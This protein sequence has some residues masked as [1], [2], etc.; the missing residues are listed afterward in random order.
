MTRDLIRPWPGPKPYQEQDA[1]LFF[2]REDDIRRI[3]SSI[4]RQ[5]LTVLLA[6]SGV[7]KTSLLQAGVLPRLRRL[8]EEEPGNVGPIVLVRQWGRP[9]PP[10]LALVEAIREELVNLGGRQAEAGKRFCE[11]IQELMAVPCPTT[12]GL[13]DA[14]DLLDAAVGY[15]YRLTQSVGRL[16]L[17]VDQAEE[18]LGS[19]LERRDPMREQRA[20]ELFASIFRRSR[21]C[22]L[23]LSLREEY[24]A[25]L[26]PLSRT[27]DGL[28]IR[29]SLIEPLPRSTV[30]DAIKMAA[31][32][33]GGVILGATN[34]EAP[35]AILDTVFEWMGGGPDEA[36]SDAEPVDLLRLQALLVEV[37]DYAIECA[38]T[39]PVDAREIVIDSRVLRDFRREL[40]KEAGR[41]VSPGVLGQQ[42][43]ERY[44]DR[45]LARRESDL[46]DTPTGLVRRLVVRMAPWL[47]SPSGFKRH[48]REEDLIFNAIRS[49]LE[50]LRLRS[51]PEEVRQALR[52]LGAGGTELA[53][54]YDPS[55]P[56]ETVSGWAWGLSQATV[57]TRLALAGLETL[58]IL[59]KEEILKVSKSDTGTLYELVHDGFGSALHEWSD[60]RRKDIGDTLAS[61]VAQCGES[62][63]WNPRKVEQQDLLRLRWLGCN[64]KGFDLTGVTFRECDLRGTIFL[65]CILKACVFVDCELDGVVFKSGRWEDVQWE[66]CAARSALVADLTWNGQIVF[67]KCSMENASIEGVGLDGE[68]VAKES[69]LRF[70]Q[71]QSIG[72]PQ[73]G[74]ITR[75]MDCDVTNALIE[76][77][78][79][80]E[81]LRCLGETTVLKV[82]QPSPKGRTTEAG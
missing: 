22:H 7:G 9:G 20:L 57:G 5:R 63:S 60:R 71:L 81:H 51:S 23:V 79:G 32:R 35:G 34:D 70:A 37:F 67:E 47:S 25:R 69:S 21:N 16:I 33:G 74:G 40:I 1:D 80:S 56:E 15:V 19:G 4:L 62:F 49:D 11:D 42:A 76:D 55:A 14:Y 2:G 58:K 59:R 29:Q 66:N 48:N 26:S 38:A 78:D 52:E 31:E 46:E 30:K 36:P 12:E 27:V 17:I 54:S 64:L 75:F 53:V 8:R 50:V 45:S 44:I 3:M 68:V 61:I 13:E 43:L 73:G 39:L 24:R 65:E 10:E 41:D 6:G 82:S 77:F 18:L 72:S 28:D